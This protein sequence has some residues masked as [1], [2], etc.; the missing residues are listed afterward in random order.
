[1]FE[2]LSVFHRE[3][4]GNFRTAT[5]RIEEMDLQAELE[6]AIKEALEYGHGYVFD[7]AID[8]DE[9]VRPMVGGGSHI[10]EFMID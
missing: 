5:L 4:N 2:F 1:M 9:M 3:T 7:C 8:T 10:T 6:D